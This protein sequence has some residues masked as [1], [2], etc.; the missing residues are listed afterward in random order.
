MKHFL[1][2][3]FLL[4]AVAIGSQAT[5][6]VERG[7]YITFGPAGTEFA[8]PFLNWQ[9]GQKWSEDDN[10]FIS[11]VKPKTRF[12]NAATQVNRTFDETND[13]KLIYWVPNGKSPNFS[14]Q[15]P[16]FDGDVFSMWSYVTHFGNWNCPFMRCPGAFLDIAHKNGVGVSTLASIP[17]GTLNFNWAVAL[18]SL[19][20]QG[21]DK[22]VEYLHQYGIDGLSY[23]SEFNVT[24]ALPDGVEKRTFVKEIANYNAEVMEKSLKYS[25]DFT[26]IWYDG[27]CYTGTIQFDFGLDTHN[28]GTFGYAEKPVSSLFL[29]YNWNRQWLIDKTLQNAEKLGRSPLDIYCGFNMQGLEPSMRSATWTLLKDAPLSIG[30]WG[31]HSESIMFQGRGERGFS[32]AAKQQTYLTRTE[33]FFTGGTRNPVNTP[34]ISDEWHC[35]ADNVNFFGMSKFMSA[36][37]ALCWD[38]SEEPFITAFNL[39]NGKFMNWR[40]TAA[41]SKPWTNISV[42]DYLPTW[43]FWFAS[44]F[45]GNEPKDVPFR[46]LDANFVWNDAWTGGSLLNISGSASEEYLHL[47]KTAFDLKDGD[48]ITLRYRLKNGN[49]R[50]NLVFSTEGNEDVAI[51]TPVQPVKNPDDSWRTVTYVVGKDLPALSGKTLAMVALRFQ[52]AND[53]DLNL[54]EFSIVRPGATATVPSTPVI[55]K[56]EVLAYNQKGVDGKIIFNMPFTKA[57]NEPVYNLDVKTSLFKIYSQANDET[58]VLE[59]ITTSWASLI[60][61]AAMPSSTGN[62]IRFGV[63]AVSLDLLSESEIAWSDYMEC[64]D[65]YSISDNIA[66]DVEEIAKDEPFSVSFTDPRHASAFWKVTDIDGNTIASAENTTTLSF[67]KGIAKTGIYNL[68]IADNA[69]MENCQ[70]YNGYIQ[71][72]DPASARTPQILTL[73]AERPADATEIDENCFGLTGEEFNYSYTGRRAD[74]V[75]SRGLLVNGDAFGTWAEELGIKGKNSFTISVWI[76]P[77]TT[78]KSFQIFSIKDKSDKWANNTWGWM[79]QTYDP[80]TKSINTSFKGNQSNLSMRFDNVALQPMAWTHLTMSFKFDNNGRLTHT[81]AI[82][83]KQV[84]CKDYTYGDASGE[85]APNPTGDLYNWREGNIIAIGGPLHTTPGFEGT[86][87]EFCFYDSAMTPEEMEKAYRKSIGADIADVMT[88]AVYFSFDKESTGY[89]FVNE[90]NARNCNAGTLR[91]EPAL[92]EGTGTL[93]W[94][95]PVFGAGAPFTT[96]DRKVKTEAEWILLNGNVEK[97]YVSDLLGNANIA[98]AATGVYNIRL[99]LY[100]EC[101]EDVRDYGFFNIAQGVAVGNISEDKSEGAKLRIE[102][103]TLFIAVSEEGPANVRIYTTDGRMVCNETIAD[104]FST[105]AALRFDYPAGIYLLH[106]TTASGKDVSVKI[107]K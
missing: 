5:N 28:F 8:E 105:P 76:R 12:R 6:A 46:S 100:N 11:R 62:K 63:S 35:H 42:Q 69:A 55:E 2:F 17:Y 19:I 21:S 4:V 41:N 78:D 84:E 30:L 88:P 50:M 80:A 64:D 3:P 33:R 60:Y 13:K 101:G 91:Y 75:R 9:K 85:G 65:L 98:F 83:G 39:G 58:P 52:W 23:N 71:I 81:M 104:A 106:V 18:R 79:W 26:N 45:M 97:K 1:K 10:F 57:D 95:E 51:E 102:G 66:I 43:R 103:E 68:M 59:A 107:R 67:E 44:K 90:A 49:T 25:P 29:N 31:E 72:L 16:S 27:T 93:V 38:L 86:I 73:L 20:D 7:S 22:M 96:S 74:G 82:N 61:D 47:F 15:I 36:R 53:L 89:N 37:S 92:V 54:G 56:A 14:F 99:R 87:D 48:V 94:L 70:T 24:G 32:D 40:G 77:N 34:E